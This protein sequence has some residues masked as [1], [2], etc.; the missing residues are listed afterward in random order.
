MTENKIWSFLG[1]P[2][3]LS[4]QNCGLVMKLFSRKR[5]RTLAQAVSCCVYNIQK[6]DAWQHPI[7]VL[8]LGLSSCSCLSFFI[9]DTRDQFKK[10]KYNCSP[11]CWANQVEYAPRERI[12]HRCWKKLFWKEQN[13]IC[14][15]LRSFVALKCNRRESTNDT[16]IVATSA[17]LSLF[18]SLYLSVDLFKHLLSLCLFF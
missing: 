1:L 14:F 8:L 13:K 15:K 9:N 2:I 3:H 6:N 5:Y 7:Y 4:Y 10:R 17:P 18:P 12:G 16:K 11:C